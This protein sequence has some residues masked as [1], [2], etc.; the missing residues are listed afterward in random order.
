MREAAVH[1][2]LSEGALRGATERATGGLTAGSRGG[3]HSIAPITVACGPSPT[4]QLGILSDWRISSSGTGPGPALYV[5]TPP[6][7]QVSERRTCSCLHGLP[8]GSI[9]FLP[10]HFLSLLADVASSVPWALTL[11]GV[12]TGE[13]ITFAEVEALR[14]AGASAIAMIGGRE[15]DLATVLRAARTAGGTVRGQMGPRLRLFGRIVPAEFEAALEMLVNSPG[16]RTIADWAAAIGESVRWLERRC[17]NEWRV[18]NPR[19]WLELVCAVRAVQI[20]Q[21]Q[22]HAS[23]ESVLARASF[24][25]AQTGRELLKKV[26]GC[27]PA[28]IRDLIGW[29][30]AVEHW[31]RFFWPEDQVIAR[32]PV[33]YSKSPQAGR[34]VPNDRALD[35]GAPIGARAE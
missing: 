29:Y 15:P 23:I 11:V 5:C 17:A 22:P 33:R 30:W 24:Q 14:C 19:R 10:N 21:A 18:P 8:R 25:K 13:T 7:S 4:R 35:A 26:C 27:S 6:Y 32:T 9:V 31:C 12:Q 3:T 16:A 28:K 2:K 20:L 1:G 34:K